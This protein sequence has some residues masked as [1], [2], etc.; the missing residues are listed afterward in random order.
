MYTLEPNGD[1]LLLKEIDFDY[2]TGSGI[3]LPGQAKRFEVEA[4]VLE[5]GP[6]VTAYK[7]GDTVLVHV[8]DGRKITMGQDQYRVIQE[9]DVMGRVVMAVPR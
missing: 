7:A 2:R 8:N 6:D 9:K 4:K 3:I 5:A 1:R